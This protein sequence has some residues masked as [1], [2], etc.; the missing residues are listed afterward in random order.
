MGANRGHWF[1]KTRPLQ[2]MLTTQMTPWI[3]RYRP[4]PNASVRLFCLPSAG[5]GASSYRDWSDDLSG[6][7]EVLPVQPPGRENRFVEEPLR[8]MDDMVASLIDALRPFMSDLPFAFFGHSLGG[9]VALEVARSLARRQGP[10]PC[11]MIVSARPAPHLPLRRV[12]VVDLSEEE[13]ESWIRGMQGTSEIVLQ[14]REMMDLIL[15]VM[16]ADLE[17][18]DT[19]RSGPDPM[20]ACP[21]TVLGGLHDEEARP[22][23]LKEWARYTRGVFTLR[24]VEGNHFFPFNEARPSALAVVEEALTAGLIDAANSCREEPRCR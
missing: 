12:P 15:P 17:I 3:A 23:E 18:D 11:H 16:R 4:R 20:L 13:L 22:E 9:I 7:I 5:S 8:R 19:Y 6:D 21:L 2:V 10:L 1:G 24:L 14:S